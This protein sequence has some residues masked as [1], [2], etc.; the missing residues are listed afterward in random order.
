MRGQEG[1]RTQGNASHSS[2][3]SP[4]Q[5]VIHGRRRGRGLLQLE[6]AAQGHADLRHVAAAHPAVARQPHR[7]GHLPQR[8]RGQHHGGSARQRAA[9]AVVF[10]AWRARC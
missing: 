10:L 4:R 5:E 6:A 2:A 7:R 1:D 3:T 8:H 9:D